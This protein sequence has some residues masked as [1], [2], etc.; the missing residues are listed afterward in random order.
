LLYQRLQVHLFP[1][2]LPLPPADPRGAAAVT[3]GVSLW[4]SLHSSRL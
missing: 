4:N 2:S 3:L 1:T